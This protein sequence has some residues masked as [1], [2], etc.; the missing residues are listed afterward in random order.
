MDFRP[1]A[2][3]RPWILGLVLLIATVALYWPVVHHPFVNYD[4]SEYVTENP[5]T[6]SGLN[7]NTVRWA[8]TTFDFVSWYPL[9]WLSHALDCQLFK[10][11]PAGHHA[12]NL[13]LHALNV[14][15]LYWV[16]QRATGFSGRSFMVAAL[17]ALHP[18]NVESVAWIA[19]RKNLLSMLFFLLALGAYR[20]YA[21]R[22]E[23][24]RYAVVF[25]LYALGLMSKPLIITFPCVLLLW[26]YWPLGRMFAQVRG[27]ADGVQTRQP[28]SSNA[29]RWLVLEKV[30]FFTLSAL[31]AYITM[32][33]TFAG[34]GMAAGKVYPFASRLQNALIS[35]AQFVGKAFWPAKLSLYYPY[36]DS[37]PLWRVL[38]AAAFMLASSIMVIACRRRYLTVGWLWFLGTL[39]PMVGLVQ[40]GIQAMADR[41]AYLPFIGLFI[42]VCWGVGEWAAAQRVSKPILIPISAAVLLSLAIVTHRQ[43][44]YWRDS[45]TLWTHAVQVTGNN[46]VAEDHLG[47]ALVAE[48]H[49]G[50]AL[51]HFYR[52][53]KIEPDDA[54]ANLNVG[55]YAQQAGDLSGAIEQYRKVVQVT[56]KS[57]GPNAVIR[58]KAFANMGYVYKKL[59]DQTQA[60]Q[61]LEV[62]VSLN[63]RFSLAWIGLGTVLQNSGDLARA[64]AAY[65]RALEDQPTDFG[66][67]LLAGALEQD[68]QHARAE[69][70]TKAAESMSQNLY[71]A[72]QI[73]AS[74]L[75]R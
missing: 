50:M 42:M 39:F 21:S 73:A 6:Q 44:D 17:F 52:A 14:L 18:L 22:P 69:E 24:G 43:I 67:L 23:A 1:P 60:R 48:G 63:P 61:C 26:D 65:S 51:P 34:G 40:V 8:F 59:G 58:A 74:L 20:W 27:A 13:F 38:A 9:T 33:A 72:R 37:L 31:S 41:F 66:Y 32:I 30:P 19:E 28:I 2:W 7:W 55:V 53:L 16:L 64:V 56:Q 35:Y 12:T 70:A 45:V 46:Y 29:L 49:S 5:H 47:G 62:A 11:N 71:E 15:L 75:K 10:L 3:K 54:I 25:G 36:P 4:D 57:I 68:G